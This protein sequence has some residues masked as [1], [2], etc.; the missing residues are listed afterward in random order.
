M[1]ELEPHE[2][3]SVVSVAFNSEHMDI[4]MAA[5]ARQTIEQTVSQMKVYRDAI[6][7]QGLVYDPAGRPRPRLSDEEAGRLL[8]AI[9]RVESRLRT[10][11]ELSESGIAS[12]VMS[13]SIRNADNLYEIVAR[14]GLI[15]L[16]VLFHLKDDFDNVTTGT[17]CFVLHE[18]TTFARIAEA[19]RFHLAPSETRDSLYLLLDPFE[20][21]VR[22]GTKPHY[23]FPYDIQ[24]TEAEPHRYLK[25]E[26]VDI[27]K[28]PGVVTRL[29]LTAC[30]YHHGIQGPALTFKMPQGTV[31]PVALVI[32]ST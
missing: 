11:L 3:N 20:S 28:T 21:S 31:T 7:D 18:G 19:L 23:V 10:A 17:R 8:W 4:A 22:P 25:V 29:C 6:H 14:M 5:I 13:Q 9:K 1:D 26:D 30:K 12:L 24:T 27:V 32:A 16:M 15:L 2:F